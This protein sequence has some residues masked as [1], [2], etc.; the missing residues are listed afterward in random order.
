LDEGRW[1]TVSRNSTDT[2]RDRSASNARM[3]ANNSN[4]WLEADGTGGFT[5]GTVNGIRTRR[6]HGLL[7]SAMTPPTGRVMLVNGFEAWLETPAGRVE[8]SAQRY[9][10]RT[11]RGRRGLTTLAQGDSC[12]WKCWSLPRDVPPL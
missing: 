3:W 6:Y 4:E 8:V 11:S 12:A 9:G 7:L 1:I 2:F 5:S 10:S